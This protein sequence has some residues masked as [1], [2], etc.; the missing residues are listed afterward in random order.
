MDA[1]VDAAPAAESV[2]LAELVKVEVMNRVLTACPSELATDCVTTV[3]VWIGDDV[4]VDDVSDV[5][6]TVELVSDETVAEDVSDAEVDVVGSEVVVVVGA[7][8]AVVTDA[9]VVAGAEVVVSGT[10]V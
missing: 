1:P 3:V 7:V 6:D 9:V 4:T 10:E 5:E 8:V 2:L